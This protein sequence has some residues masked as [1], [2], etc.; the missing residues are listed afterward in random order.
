MCMYEGI[1]EACV[2]SSRGLSPCDLVIE[3]ILKGRSRTWQF[4]RDQEFYLRLDTVVPRIKEDPGDPC[5]ENPV[6]LTSRRPG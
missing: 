2:K 4:V 3:Q 1:Y 6:V 5:R